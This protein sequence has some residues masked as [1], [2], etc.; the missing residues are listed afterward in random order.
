MQLFTQ[1][2]LREMSVN[3]EAFARRESKRAVYFGGRCYKQTGFEGRPPFRM[4]GKNGRPV[5][6]SAIVLPLAAARELRRRAATAGAP[7]LAFYV[8]RALGLPTG[9]AKVAKR[10][11][12]N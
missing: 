3:F 12:Q 9:G 11:R 2:E 6:W 1:A 4:Q 5:D 10:G 7:S 8:C